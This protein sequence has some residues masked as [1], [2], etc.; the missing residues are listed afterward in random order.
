MFFDELFYMEMYCCKK[1]SSTFTSHIIFLLYP[2]AVSD[3]VRQFLRV[4]VA[5]W[6]IYTGFVLG[7]IAL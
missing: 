5:T 7:A 6:E 1:Q 3:E 2:L 4:D